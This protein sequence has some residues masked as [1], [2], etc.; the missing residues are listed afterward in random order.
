MHY[1]YAVEWAKAIATGPHAVSAMYAPSWLLADEVD[2]HE[3]RHGYD[4]Q[5]LF[6]SACNAPLSGPHLRVRSYTGG[7]RSGL[8][9]WTWLREADGP[10]A[11]DGPQV[12]GHTFHTYD[13]DGLILSESTWWD[14]TA[15]HQSPCEAAPLRPT[16]LVTPQAATKAEASFSPAYGMHHATRWC[17]AWSSGAE[18]LASLYALRFAA[19]WGTVANHPDDTAS[20]GEELYRSLGRIA[21]HDGQHRFVAE[22]ARTKSLGHVFFRWSVWIVGA[23]A[24]RGLATDGRDL[25]A[26]GSTFHE[27]A[28]DGRIRFESTMWDAPELVS[29]LR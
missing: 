29:G 5:R 27:F 22:E 2:G 25:E 28:S 17:D 19:E 24:Y 26:A 18:D 3:V 4:L 23:T 15:L 20:T 9:R 12:D 6:T 16:E 1:S 7:C 10:D 14:A 21:G 13:P 8:I 11:G